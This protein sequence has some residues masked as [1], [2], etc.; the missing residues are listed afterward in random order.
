MAEILHFEILR[1]HGQTNTHT[2]TKTD[3]HGHYNT[4]PSPYGGRGNN[5]SV[6]CVLSSSTEV[7]QAIA[8]LDNGKAC[9][10]DNIFSENLKYEGSRISVLLS[11][12]F[13]AFLIHGY[14]PSPMIDTIRVPVV[15]N[16]AGD[17]TD[18]NNYRPIALASIVSKVFEL[19]LLNRCE[20]Y[21]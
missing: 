20:K 18:H 2:N 11:L 12:C 15:K 4:S 14:L 3:R 21:L 16:K 7:S 8:S 1:K 6:D 5:V 19:I 17:I 13:N 9:G 10:L